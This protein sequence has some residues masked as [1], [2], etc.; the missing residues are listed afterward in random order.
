MKHKQL[1]AYLSG[2]MEYA[3]NEGKDWR[4]AT[5][6]WLKD[7][8][9]HSAYNPNTESE[10]LLSQY[11]PDGDFRTL[12][13]TDI[14]RYSTIVRR[15]VKLDCQ[16][17]ATKADYIIC[18]WNT[19]AQRGAGTKGELTMARYFKKPVYMVTTMKAE[20]IPGWVLG[21]VDKRF[22]TF[23]ELQ[24]FLVKHYGTIKKV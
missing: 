22:R 19:G 10:D 15:M 1:R 6:A 18:L 3:K 8:L 16:E 5:E 7:M 14:D 21:C 24:A 20:K 11:L 12:K 13:E 4:D 23:S 9:G 2:G 17:V